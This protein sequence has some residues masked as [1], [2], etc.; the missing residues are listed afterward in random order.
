MK[1]FNIYSSGTNASLVRELP[2]VGL[3]TPVPSCRLV[4]VAAVSPLVRCAWRVVK[5]SSSIEECGNS[6]VDSTPSWLTVRG[7]ANGERQE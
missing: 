5:W 2:A 6:S 3:E 7:V 1:T 4:R